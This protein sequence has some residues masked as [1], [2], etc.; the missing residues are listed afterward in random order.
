MPPPECSRPTCSACRSGERAGAT[1]P[2][3]PQGTQQ[4]TYMG[5]SR[6]NTHQKKTLVIVSDTYIHALALADYIK[7]T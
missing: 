1:A 7:P 2:P 6:R 5:T 4:A 3:T